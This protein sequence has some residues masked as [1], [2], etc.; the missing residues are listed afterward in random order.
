MTRRPENSLR[1]W[2]NTSELSPRYPLPVTRLPP[3]SAPNSYIHNA[4][5]SK[6]KLTW[7]FSPNSDKP[8]EVEGFPQRS[9]HIEV[10]L[11]NDKGE[12]VPANVFDKVTFHLHP[13]F[14]ERATQST[15]QTQ[16]TNF[17]VVCPFPS[18]ATCETVSRFTSTGSYADAVYLYL[19][20]FQE[21]SVPYCRGGMG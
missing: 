9:W 18:M 5:G 8:S 13:S 12:L 2:A 19:N 6:P 16:L 20:S 1:A 11:V 7:T 14:G 15:L 3:P 4:V 21:P 17:A 10:W